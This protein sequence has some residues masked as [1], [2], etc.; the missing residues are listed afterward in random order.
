GFRWRTG[1]RDR[2]GDPRA[3]RRGRRRRGRPRRPGG[4]SSAAAATG[5]PSAGAAGPRTPG[6]PSPP[7]GPPPAGRG[8]PRRPFPP[9]PR[10]GRAGPALLRRQGFQLLPVEGAVLVLVPQLD[11]VVHPLGQFVLGHLAVAVLVERHH[12]FDQVVLGHPA[13]SD[14]PVGDERHRGQ[15]VRELLV[16]GVRQGLLHLREQIFAGRLRRLA[17]GAVIGGEGVV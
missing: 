11:Q 12:P 8:R 1:F 3:G 4:A 14:R 10:P 13:G 2:L 5:P 17:D 6:P 16:L 9:P 15:L 7:A